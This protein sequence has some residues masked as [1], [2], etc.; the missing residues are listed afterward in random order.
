[1]RGSVPSERRL[2][3]QTQKGREAFE[4]ASRPDAEGGTRTPTVAMTTRSLVW[5]V[6][7]FRHFRTRVPFERTFLRRQEGEL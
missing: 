7:Q 6:Y 5:R 3:T 2:Y 1:M 4:D